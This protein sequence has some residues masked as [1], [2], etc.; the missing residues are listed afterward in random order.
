MGRMGRFVG[1]AAPPGSLEEMERLDADL[2]AE[3][4]SRL[5]R[6]MLDMG[7]QKG[8]VEWNRK[9]RKHGYRRVP[10]RPEQS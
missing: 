5:F 8:Y 1:M 4:Y 7:E 6:Q 10:E 3:E 2:L 9:L